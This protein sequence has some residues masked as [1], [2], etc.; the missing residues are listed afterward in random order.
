MMEKMEVT[1][2]RMLTGSACYQK[3]VLTILRIVP[4]E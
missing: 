4:Y 2:Y 1:D 3:Y